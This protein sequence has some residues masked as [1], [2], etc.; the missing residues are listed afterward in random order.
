[1]KGLTELVN[2]LENNLEKLLEKQEVLMQE[3][4]SLNLKNDE[5]VT[6]TENQNQIIKRYFLVMGFN[7]NV[8]YLIECVNYKNLRITYILI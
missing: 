5:L 1:M 8:Y 4:V 3:I 2:L 7:K 6:L